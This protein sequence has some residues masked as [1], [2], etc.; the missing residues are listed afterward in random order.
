MVLKLANQLNLIG[1]TKT[2]KKPNCIQYTEERLNIYKK[3]HYKHVTVMNK[4]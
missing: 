4:N 1:V 2:F 3:K